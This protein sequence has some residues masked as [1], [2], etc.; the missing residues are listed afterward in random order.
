MMRYMTDYAQIKVNRISTR[1]Q[2]LARERD[3]GHRPSKMLLGMYAL[4]AFTLLPCKLSLYEKSHVSLN[5]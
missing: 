2:K 4:E 5:V 1:W 3:K